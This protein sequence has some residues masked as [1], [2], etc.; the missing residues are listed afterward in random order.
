[1]LALELKMDPVELRRKNFVAPHKFPYHRRSAG[2]TIAGIT[3]A[4]QL[5]LKTVGYEALRK[6]QAEKLRRA[7]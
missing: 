4:M 7:S 6:E 2:P 1:M 3:A 5:A